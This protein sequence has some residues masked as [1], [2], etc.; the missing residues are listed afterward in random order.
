MKVEKVVKCIPLLLAMAN[1][2]LREAVQE[3]PGR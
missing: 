1:G 3:R 2:Y